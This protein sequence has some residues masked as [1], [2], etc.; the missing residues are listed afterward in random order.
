MR[1]NIPKCVGMGYYDLLC[2]YVV[3]GCVLLSNSLHN[4]VDNFLQTVCIHSTKIFL[5]NTLYVNKVHMK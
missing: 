1:C 3:S 5:S 4:L 2:N